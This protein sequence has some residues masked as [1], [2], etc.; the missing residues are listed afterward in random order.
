M[1]RISVVPSTCASWLSEISMLL[2]REHPRRARPHPGLPCPRFNPSSRLREGRFREERPE[3]IFAG[4]KRKFRDLRPGHGTWHPRNVYAVSR[5]LKSDCRHS[6]GFDP[7]PSQHFT[8]LPCE[9][10]GLQLPWRLAFEAAGSGPRPVAAP[11]AC[12]SGGAPCDH[13]AASGGSS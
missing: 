8:L 2:C 7:K 13:L 11:W 3:E 1:G 9:S 12:A 5:E 6:I 10:P 4:R